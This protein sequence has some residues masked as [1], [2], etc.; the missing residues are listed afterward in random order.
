MTDRVTTDR[1]TVLKT[2]SGV[3]ACS[4]VG[5][6]ATGS[7]AASHSDDGTAVRVN[8]VGYPADSHKIAIVTSEFADVSSVSSFEVQDADGNVEIGRAHV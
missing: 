1:R 8:Q 3:A 6:F 7:V 2:V 5:R 4:T